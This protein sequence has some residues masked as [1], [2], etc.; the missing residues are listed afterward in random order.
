MASVTKEK[1]YKRILLKL[2]GEELM[3]DEGFGIDPKILD[4]MALEIGQLVGIGVQVGLVIGGGNLFRGAALNAAGMDRVTG[5][6][7]GMLATV[8]NALAMRDALERTNISSHV[9]SSIPMSGVVEHYDRRR[10]IRYLKEGDVVIFAAGTG[11]PF[12]TTDSAACLRG[13]EIDANVV[14]KATKVDG[15]YSADPML[16]PKAELFQ[17]L[18]YDEVLDKKLEVMDLTAICLCREHSMPLRVFRMSKPGA[19]LNL[20]VGGD[21]GT[22][23]Q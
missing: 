8:M 21:E 15:V 13:I 6:H 20:V 23:I 2:S 11:N 22:L 10:A 16:E 7:M 18:T 12:F 17:H 4:R 14:L 3:G 5:D 9:M 1:K 19:L